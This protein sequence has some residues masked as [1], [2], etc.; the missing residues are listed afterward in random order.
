MLID[1]LNQNDF[2]HPMEKKT[3]LLYFSG[4]E[5]TEEMVAALKAQNPTNEPK[6]DFNKP[7]V[8]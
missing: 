1:I 5:I 6:K 7:V 8:I 2:L 3:I 4:V